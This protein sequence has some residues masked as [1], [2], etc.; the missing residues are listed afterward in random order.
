M[1]ELDICVR[2]YRS[3]FGGPVGVHFYVVV[4]LF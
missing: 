1:L 2:E 3:F 4:V